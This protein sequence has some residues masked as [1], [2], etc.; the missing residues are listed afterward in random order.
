[1]SSGWAR[2]G[3]ITAEVPQC[4]KYQP[5][6]EMFCSL[7]GCGGCQPLTVL[8][9]GQSLCYS[10]RT[11]LFTPVLP[12]PSACLPLSPCLLHFSLPSLAQTKSSVMLDLSCLWLLC[13]YCLW[14]LVSQLHDGFID[15][16]GYKKPWIFF[17]PQTSTK[18]RITLPNRSSFRPWSTQDSRLG[19]SYLGLWRIASF[20][21]HK[22]NTELLTSIA[23]PWHLLFYT[24]VPQQ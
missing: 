9:V 13:V 23:C 1:M 8:C 21:S 22:G 16:Y 18:A 19:F 14:N 6:N 2:W 7:E 5:Q 24:I 11:C 4:S 15:G 20:F 17:P 12:Q 10:S 3:K